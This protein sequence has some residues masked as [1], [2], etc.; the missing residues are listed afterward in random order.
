[1]FDLRLRVHDE[2]SE[3]IQR[4]SEGKVECQAKELGP[5]PLVNEHR[6]DVKSAEQD[7]DGIL[8]P[9][10]VNMQ[11]DSGAWVGPR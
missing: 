8:R 7:S 9:G 4:G 10:L 5:H 11:I 6:E 3:A 2:S 1:M